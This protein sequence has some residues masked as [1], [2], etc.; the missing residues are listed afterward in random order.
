VKAT[1]QNGGDYHAEYRVVSGE[2]P[3]HWIAARGKTEFSAD[4]QPLRMR[5]VSIDIT[6]GKRSEEALR[7]NEERFSLVVEVSPNAMV[8]LNSEGSI[9]MAQCSGGDG[10]ELYD[11]TKDFSQNNDLAAKNPD[12][13]KEMQALSKT[14]RGNTRSCPWTT[15]ASCAC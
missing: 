12:K 1:L 14:E 7:E 13:L 15:R 4:G 11:L 5:G 10:W 6:E 9:T 8:I 2:A 3:P